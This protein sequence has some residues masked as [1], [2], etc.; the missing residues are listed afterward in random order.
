MFLALLNFKSL[1]KIKPQSTIK[2][3]DCKSMS[4]T[5]LTIRFCIPSATVE[6]FSAKDNVHVAHEQQ[7]VLSLPPILILVPNLFSTNA[8]SFR[9]EA[10]E[11]KAETM[12]GR[13]AIKLECRSLGANEVE[14]MGRLL[15]LENVS[16]KANNL[17]FDE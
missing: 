3:L 13:N 8:E 14:Q 2:K 17:R 1:I 12:T 6:E 7:H 11:E 5:H 15:P 16:F 4:V 10:D 9:C